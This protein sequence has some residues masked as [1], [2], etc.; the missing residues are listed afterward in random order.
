MLAHWSQP[1]SF[2][3]VPAQG[4]YL[5]NFAVQANM[6][7]IHGDGGGFIFRA[8]DNGAYRFR[9]SSDGTYDLVNGNHMLAK[10]SSSAVKMGPNQ[11]NLLAIIVQR[12][13]IYVYI[14]RQLV[15]KVVDSTL[16]YGT[17]EALALDF[18]NAAKVRFDNIQVF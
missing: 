10:G 9:M 2:I 14:N 6:T 5:S 3:M 18:T 11:T 4:L 15:T 8:G 1:N 12:H 13:T 16:N 7:I 17:L